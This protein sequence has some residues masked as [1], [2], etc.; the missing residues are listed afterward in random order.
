MKIR[1]LGHRL[2]VG[3]NPHEHALRA[4][5]GRARGPSRTRRL[6]DSCIT[7]RLGAVC[8][9]CTRC[10]LFTGEAP[11]YRGLDGKN[12]DK[13]RRDVALPTELQAPRVDPVGFEP[14]T[15][16]VIAM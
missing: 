9:S 4:A 2:T 1:A 15:V 5:G 11:H 10:V 14:T 16:S 13:D 12:S 8:G 3:C 7:V 6:R